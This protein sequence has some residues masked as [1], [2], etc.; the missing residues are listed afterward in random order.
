M[1]AIAGAMAESP[2]GATLD[3]GVTNFTSA[4]ARLRRGTRHA[5]FFASR[6]A[7]VHFYR[8]GNHGLQRALAETIVDELRAVRRATQVQE[9]AR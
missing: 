5:R 7:A 3:P 2:A 1:I 4:W 6:E 9:A 8:F